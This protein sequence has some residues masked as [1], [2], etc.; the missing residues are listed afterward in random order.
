MEIINNRNGI[1]F[2]I[3]NEFKSEYLTPIIKNLLFKAENQWDD[4]NE[5]YHCCEL[6]ENVK[7]NMDFHIMKKGE[8]YLGIAL[9]SHGI[10][11]YKTFFNE[12]IQIN[13]DT[14][15]ILIFNYFHI[16]KEGRGNG[17]MWLKNI[18]EYY[19]S[20]HYKAIYLK[21]SHPKV[22]SMYNRLGLEIG[23]YS[24]YSD[25]NLF[26]RKGKVFKIIL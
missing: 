7:M 20:K 13:E 6:I 9:V 19:K 2:G 3:S 1:D 16:S 4:Y 10:L 21:S 14:K 18:I 11:D 22:F 24:I 25:N 8:K 23:E 17:E 5:V 26:E 12:S 15:D